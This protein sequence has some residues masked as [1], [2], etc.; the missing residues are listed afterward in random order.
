MN[1]F[2]TLI[3]LLT[4]ISIML[5]AMTACDSNDGA[6]E[7]VGEKIDKAA[8]DL[9]NKVEDGCEELKEGLNAKDSNC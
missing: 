3:K 8:T 9:G 6:M 2:T 4:M 5:F 7:Q 1:K